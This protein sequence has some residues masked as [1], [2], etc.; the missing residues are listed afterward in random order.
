[1]GRIDLEIPGPASPRSLGLGD[2]DRPFGVE[3]VRL[4]VKARP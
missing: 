4:E 3:L 1:V 2:D